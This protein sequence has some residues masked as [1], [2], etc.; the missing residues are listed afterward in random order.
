MSS[1]WDEYAQKIY[2]GKIKIEEM[3]D[4]VEFLRGFD[5]VN[6]NIIG[7]GLKRWMKPS[8][9]EFTDYLA[10]EG[11]LKGKVHP[12]VLNYFI[13]ALHDFDHANEQVLMYSFTK[14]KNYWRKH[15]TFRN[16]MGT[17]KD[18]AWVYSKQIRESRAERNS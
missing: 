2:T 8:G 10:F 13:G 3:T 17:F 16:W 12:H 1:L 15:H 7:D 11:H 18:G 14:N 5:A 9:Y 4:L 6:K